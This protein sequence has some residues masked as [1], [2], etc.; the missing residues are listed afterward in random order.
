MVVD[1]KC[2]M[3]AGT[4]H[5]FQSP[6]SG[7]EFAKDGSI[8]KIV[9]TNARPPRN[10]VQSPEAKCVFSSGWELPEIEPNT[11]GV[12]NT[13]TMRTSLDETT[14]VDVRR[15][16]VQSDVK[17]KTK[18][19][20]ENAS[21]E[22]IHVRPE[23]GQ[24]NNEDVRLPMSPMSSQ[25]AAARENKPRKDAFVNPSKNIGGKQSKLEASH[26]AEKENT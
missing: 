2:R 10:P 5:P 19:E 9:K 20:R 24:K 17:V 7:F 12:L 8:V 13:P 25:D 18:Q 6:A 1:S 16:D 11:H 14:S 26:L 22:E 21:K 4:R 3:R 15:A 23:K